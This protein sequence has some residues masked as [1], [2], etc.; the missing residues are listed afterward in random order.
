MRPKVFAVVGRGYGD[1]GK[2]LATDYLASLFEGKTCVVRHNG[3]AQSGHT[4]EKRSGER[5]VFHELSSGSFAGA[6]TLWVNTFFPDLYKLKEEAED[7]K[8]V[9]GYIPKICAESDTPI[10]LIFDVLLNMAQEEKRG[11]KRHGSCG[12]GINEADLRCKAGYKV[13]LNDAFSLSVD[14]LSKRLFEIRDSYVKERIEELKISGVTEY[15]DLLASDD[16]VINFC[17]EIKENTAFVTLVSDLGKF[18][19]RY[20]TVIF[21]TGQGLLLDA[22]NEENAPHVTASKTGLTNIVSAVSRASLK[23]DTV[24]YVSR[25][26]LTRHGAGPLKNESDPSFLN[27]YETDLTNVSNEWQGSLRYA[28]FSSFDDF[29]APITA[30]LKS[31]EGAE[32]AILL[33]H[34]NETGGCI[35]LAGSDASLEEMI[36][37]AAKRGIS[38]VY[39]SSSRFSDE[40]VLCYDGGIN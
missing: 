32:T 21:E 7:F 29:F 27:A 17:K 8:A 37:E 11:D 35:K 28:R 13:T 9:S 10:T 12:L 19:S 23:L 3:G 36:N 38:K 1:E 31:D 16:V 4:V 18:L 15:A 25:S 20:D 2:G 5:F 40:C 26:Y 14:N 39:T 22:D 6:D 34:L 30:D 24:F 33:T